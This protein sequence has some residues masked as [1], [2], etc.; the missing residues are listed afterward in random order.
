MGCGTSS[1]QKDKK[2][3]NSEAR[4]HKAHNHKANEHNKDHEQQHK[5]KNEKHAHIKLTSKQEHEKCGSSAANR[6]GSVKRRS[7]GGGKQKK[8]G[9]GAFMNSLALQ[10][11]KINKSFNALY[12]I[13]DKYHTTGEG[14]KENIPSNKAKEVISQIA[15]EKKFT[16][17]ELH[18]MFHIAD[19]NGDKLIS[20]REFLIDI[21][22][23]YYLKLTTDDEEILKIQSGFKVVETAFKHIDSDGSGSIDVAEMKNALFI[24]Q[25]GSDQE[26]LEERFKELDFN[27]DGKVELPE[28][29]FTMVSWVGFQDEEEDDE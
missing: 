4:D 27:A 6:P 20:F 9:G 11:P 15:K 5:D 1:T 7:S 3:G 2:H 21:A 10:F 16:D 26:I 18:E 14:L 24:G 13:F 23:G 12:K 19:L 25:S 8:G 17:D 28:F 29:I 22:I